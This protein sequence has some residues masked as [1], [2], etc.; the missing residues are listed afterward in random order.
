[1]FLSLTSLAYLR[2]SEVTG[3]HLNY[4]KFWNVD[5]SKFAI[6]QIKLSSR[7][8]MLILYTPAFLAA[9][10]SFVLFPHKYF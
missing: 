9:F 2:F 5:S 7:T 10:T 1:Q 8:G 3:Q 6:K 4:S